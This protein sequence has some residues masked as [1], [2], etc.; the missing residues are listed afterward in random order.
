MNENR[1]GYE[2]HITFLSVRMRVKFPCKMK[3]EHQGSL[4]TADIP[5]SNNENRYI[6]N[7]D[8]TLKNEHLQT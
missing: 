7:Q 8:L 4:M 5:S 1:D 6:F 2:Y 3:I